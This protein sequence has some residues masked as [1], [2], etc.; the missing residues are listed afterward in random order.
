MLQRARHLHHAPALSRQRFRLLS[1]VSAQKLQQ[2]SPRHRSSH[3]EPGNQ[4]DNYNRMQPY[5]RRSVQLTAVNP[6]RPP[7]SALQTWTGEKESPPVREGSASAARISNM[8][9]STVLRC[10]FSVN[11]QY[12][13]CAD[14]RT[15]P[16]TCKFP[17]SGRTVADARWR[18]RK[19]CPNH[20]PGAP[21]APCLS[22]GPVPCVIYCQHIRRHSRNPTTYVSVHTGTCSMTDPCS[23]ST[24]Q[25]CCSGGPREVYVFD[26]G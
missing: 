8:H 15:V 23:R 19:H 25:N 11:S 21:S 14:S 20:A 4:Y 12:S 1:P 9:C 13:D 16:G 3:G 7:P 26:R 24:V 5:V 2:R 10:P 17:G 22:S 18:W 6:R